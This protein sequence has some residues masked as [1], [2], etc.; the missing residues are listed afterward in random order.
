MPEITEILPPE[1]ISK[2]AYQKQDVQD[3][4][5]VIAATDRSQLN[6]KIYSDAHQAKALVNVVDRP[7]LCD[8]MMPALVQRGELQIAISSG[9]NSPALAK[10]LRQEL[11]GK[12]EA[13]Y[14]DMM[15]IMGELRTLIKDH[16]REQNVRREI[17]HKLADLVHIK[18]EDNHET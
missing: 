6:K 12:Y 16:V 18:E 13:D 11:E 17:F 15:D 10:K 4:L 7:E 2:R 1:K 14:A 5:L 9:G 3:K 8:F